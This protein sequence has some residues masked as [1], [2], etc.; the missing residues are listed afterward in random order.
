MRDRLQ[1]GVAAIFVVAALIRI[2]FAVIAP[3]EPDQVTG[4]LSV[5]NDEPAHRSVVKYWV[6]EGCHPARGVD[7]QKPLPI[8][9]GNVV[10]RTGEDF[11]P[12]L[13]YILGS[14][15]YQFGP[16]LGLNS[17]WFLPRLLSIIFAIVALYFTWMA[18]RLVLSDVESIA[19]LAFGAV[20]LSHVRFTSIVTNDSLLW[21][22]SAAVIYLII[23]RGNGQRRH[24]RLVLIIL[25][26]AGLWTKVSFLALVLVLPVAWL[27]GARLEEKRRF[28]WLEFFIP[29]VCWIPWLYWNL[30]NW[31]ELLPIAVGFG[32]PTVP[33][34]GI[35]RIISTITYTFR[36]FW[37][38]FDGIW[39]GGMRPVMFVLLGIFGL[40]IAVL[41]VVEIFRQFEMRKI[42][43]IQSM[44]FKG[45]VISL[46]TLG[47]VL[48]SFVAL[49]IRYYQ[50]EAR[51]LFPAFI[52][53]VILL[54]LGSR[55]LALTTLGPWMLFIMAVFSYE[56]FL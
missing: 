50:C 23:L 29:V 46:I 9:P 49:N 11:Q 26:A 15:A 56:L 40:I 12:P 16:L 7:P 41:A 47:L 24:Y 43:P 31:G 33:H 32:V 2:F 10:A 52:P 28:P 55:R 4:K 45:I 17:L 18:C 25:L 36:S 6:Q 30:Q 3:L 19:A 51:L 48:V 42:F 39:G 27:L 8:E 1:W 22:I 35:E 37:F 54:M 21:A 14:A 13:Y 5:Y 34:Y 38:P 53:I 44:E 20:L